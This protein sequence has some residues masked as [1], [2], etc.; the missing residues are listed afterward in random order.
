ML[1]LRPFST[2]GRR[3]AEGSLHLERQADPPLAPVPSLP[4]EASEARDSG[5]SD[6]LSED[7]LDLLA[8]NTG[9]FVRPSKAAAPKKAS[10]KKL[11]RRKRSDLSGS[12]DSGA[13]EASDDNES[14]GERE[15]DLDASDLKRIFDDRPRR[16]DE[17]EDDD[18]EDD[19]ADFIEEDEREGEDEEEKRERKR[20]ERERRKKKKQGGKGRKE[21]D[22]GI[23]K[24]CVSAL[25]STSTMPRPLLTICRPPP[26][27]LG[28]HLRGLWQRRRVRLGARRRGRDVWRGRRRRGAQDFGR[29]SSPLV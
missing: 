21:G 7:D 29:A 27:D 25:P 8:E 18:D 3:F 14:G 13:G 12:D 16:G 22:G 11:L 5:D 23:S 2:T 1:R 10:K 17:D 28:R 26:Q 20:Q 6:A 24:S 4:S 9:A 19:L 15:K